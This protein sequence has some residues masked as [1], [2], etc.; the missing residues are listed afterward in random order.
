MARMRRE[1]GSSRRRIAV[2]ALAASVL[3]GVVV[4][5]ALAEQGTAGPLPPSPPPGSG[6]AIGDGGSAAGY[7]SASP[8]Q[9]ESLFKNNFSATV[10][11]LAS[12]PADLSGQHP[13]FLDNHT[14]V[15]STTGNGTATATEIESILNQDRHDLAAA[16]S[17]LDSLLGQADQGPESSQLVSSVLPLRASDGDGQAPVDLSL[18]QQ[19]AAYSPDNPLVD[20][21]LPDDL[22]DQVTIGDQ[23]IKVD[24]GVDD[25][26]SADPIAGD[27]LFYADAAPATDVVLA[28][29]SSGLETFYQLRAP[30]SP[31][32]FRM[33]FTLP[34]GAQLTDTGDGGA[35]IRRDGNTLGVVYPP[36]AV[37]GAG[38]PVGVSMSVDGDSL[39]LDVPHSD[40]GISYPISVD[41]VVDLYTWSTN[42]AGRFADWIQNKTVGSPYQLSTACTQGVNC[43]GGLAPTGLYVVAPAGQSVAANATGA[44]QYSVPHYPS[45]SAYISTLNVGP[46]RF[47]PRSDPTAANPATNPF[48]FAGVFPDSTGN[49]YVVS[50]TQNQAASNLYWNLNPGTATT[51]KKAVFSLWSFVARQVV[52][53]RDAYLGGA[54]I[55][56]GDTDLPTLALS[57]SG[58]TIGSADWS[59]SNWVDDTN[60][61]VTVNGADA[62]LGVKRMLVPNATNLAVDQNIP[63]WCDGTNS[64][65]CPQSPQPVTTNYDTGD[66]PDGV[67][68]TGAAAYDALDKVRSRVFVLR[69][70]HSEPEI[71][72]SGGLSGDD[73]DTPGLLHVVASDGD[74]SDTSGHA[75]QSGVRSIVVQVDG[76]TVADTGQ[77]DCTAQAGSCSLS[78]DYTLDP[79]DYVGQDLHFEVIATDELGHQHAE[80]WD[81]HPPATLDCPQPTPTVQSAPNPMSTS[82]A[83]QQAI[84]ATVAPSQSTYDSELAT[85]IDPSLSRPDNS[86]PTPLGSVG[87]LSDDDVGSAA[88]GGFGIEQVLCLKPMQ[89]TANETSAEIVNGD[90]ALYA[91]AATDTDTIVRPTATGETVIQSLR[92][93]GSPTSFSW[94]VGL[95]DDLQ[96]QQLSSGAIALVDPTQDPPE[97]LTVPNPPNAQSPGAIANASTQ[98]AQ[99]RYEVA[100]AEQET[101]YG[102]EGVIARPYTVDASGNTTVA[103]MTLTGDTI[104]VQSN[105]GAKA[106]VLAALSNRTKGVRKVYCRGCRIE[107]NTAISDGKHNLTYQNYMRIHADLLFGIYETHEGKVTYY[108][109]ARG[110]L[111]VQVDH[112]NGYRSKAWCADRSGNEDLLATCRYNKARHS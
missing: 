90:S 95:R 49:N 16:Q 44:W 37:D 4:V 22:D 68:I 87:T 34:A 80:V 108:E 110:P 109:R 32:H 45:T 8:A 61:S 70:D 107:A 29:I 74:A 20:V 23:G 52:D 75:W 48:M 85:Q 17:D 56:L 71:V 58:V 19:G 18:D 10:D 92:G 26:S 63:E 40:A 66:L 55:W 94:K 82:Q 104:T 105:P 41:P 35:A 76:Q 27:N 79:E 89:T 36:T 97:D 101:G 78:L 14:A 54:A 112:P 6:E 53:W 47:S 50:Q 5:P 7:P 98:M 25:A 96:L 33:T 106:L 81:L 39:E 42:G 103:T 91:N 99:S 2:F 60:A 24:L 38:T 59:Y 13:D 28:P 111:H 83:S 51:G 9:A 86:P 31:D 72:T 77:H 88:A 57:H 30:E 67:T 1:W 12:D 93:A 100:V 84:A 43:Q 21:K 46:M 73:T 65:R 62:G 69:V 102:V 15:V 64:A 3:F 11:S